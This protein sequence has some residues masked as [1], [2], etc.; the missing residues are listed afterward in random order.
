M[1]CINPNCCEPLWC[2]FGSCVFVV[3]VIVLSVAVFVVVVSEKH[4]AGDLQ[5]HIEAFNSEPCLEL[6]ELNRFV[7]LIFIF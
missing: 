4:K 7:F 6:V 5:L 2:F 3:F 1:R